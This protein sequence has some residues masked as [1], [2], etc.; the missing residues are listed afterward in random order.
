MVFNESLFTLSCEMGKKAQVPSLTLPVPPQSLCGK[1]PPNLGRSSPAVGG[2]SILSLPFFP[3]FHYIR[4]TPILLQRGTHNPPFWLPV[5]PPTVPIPL[6]G[7]SFWLPQSRWWGRHFPFHLPTPLGPR[8][9]WVWFLTLIFNLFL[10]Q[11]CTFW[12]GDTR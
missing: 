7:F 11:K 4:G 3:K 9:C 2:Y 6:G 8:W 10:F 1:G 12:R 5:C